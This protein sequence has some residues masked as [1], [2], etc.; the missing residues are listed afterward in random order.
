VTRVASSPIPGELAAHSD[1]PA[2]AIHNA[3]TA[4]ASQ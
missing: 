4:P 2:T 3:L 1:Q